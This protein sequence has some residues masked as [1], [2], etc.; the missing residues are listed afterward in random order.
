MS[1]NYSSIGKQKI[2]WGNAAKNNSE[3]IYG[4]TWG[5]P[6][7]ESSTDSSGKILGNYKKI[8][9][10]FILKYIN[11]NTTIIDLG[12]LSGKWTQFFLDAGKIICVDISTEGYDSIKKHLKHDNME[13]YQTKGYELDGIE[14]NSID[15]VFCMDTLVRSEPGIIQDYLF[16]IKRVIKDDGRACIHLPCSDIVGSME[17]GFTGITIKEIEGMCDNAGIENFYIKKF[18]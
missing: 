5:D 16:E 3:K 8:K 6:T 12:S 14:S 15:I 13:F 10:E 7:H 18:Y 17:R 2:Q 9:D 4:Y 11:E 1:K